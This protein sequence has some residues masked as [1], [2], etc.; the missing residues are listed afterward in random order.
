MTSKS[1]SSGNP[2][3]MHLFLVSSFTTNNLQALPVT[4]GV[5]DR[6]Q[7]SLMEKE[8]P[9]NSP[10]PQGDYSSAEETRLKGDTHCTTPV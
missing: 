1:Q 7:G 4:H 5:L 10:S 3:G 2:V 8:R 6:G 9:G